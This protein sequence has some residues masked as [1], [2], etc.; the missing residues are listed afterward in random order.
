MD[1]KEIIKEVADIIQKNA[2]VEAVFGKPYEKGNITIIPVSKSSIYCGGGGGAGE[3]EEFE[4]AKGLGIG[5]GT[6]IKTIPVG[7]IEIDNE[8]ARFVEVFQNSKLIMAGI[9]LGAFSV[10]SLTRLLIKL[11]KK[12]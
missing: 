3:N 4:K 12:K 9:A 2:N 6:R 10:Y 1:A 11:I 7:Y 8:G 5:M